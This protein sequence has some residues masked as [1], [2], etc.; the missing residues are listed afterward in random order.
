MNKKYNILVKQNNRQ[1]CVEVVEGL[2]NA[3]FVV[4]T[5]YSHIYDSV[6]VVEQNELRE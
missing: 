1:W 2:D 3:K 4:D 5:F 6:N